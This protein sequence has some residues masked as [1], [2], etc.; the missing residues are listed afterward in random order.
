M[1]Q[2]LK[3]LLINADSF[4]D[5]DTCGTQSVMSFS[6]LTLDLILGV[7]FFSGEVSVISI[8]SCYSSSS[9]SKNFFKFQNLS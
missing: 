8:T 5:V 7:L 4:L 1:T 6:G 9:S 2:V 3:P